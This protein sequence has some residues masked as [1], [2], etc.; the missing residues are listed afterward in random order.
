ML[1][2]IFCI[3]DLVGQPGRTFLANALPVL[4][5]SRNID[6]VVANAEN[7]A[8]GSGLTPQIFQK[9]LHYGVDVVTLGDHC[10]KR[11]EIIPIMASSDQLVRPAN[12]PPGAAGKP[13]TVVRKERGITIGVTVLLGRLYMK[14]MDCPYRTAD[15]MLVEIKKHTPIAIV[16]MHAE[17]TSEKIAMGW[18]LDGRA[19]IVFGTHTHVPTADARILP[20]GTAYITDLGMTGPYEGVLGRNREKVIRS[21]ISGMPNMYDIAEKDNRVAGVLVTVE[22]TTGRAVA[23]EQMIVDELQIEKMKEELKAR[24]VNPPDTMPPI[25]DD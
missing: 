7:A 14:P 13:Y 11:Y 25:N 8:G 19:S 15:Q 9:L 10:Y 21:M 6:V 22:T 23:I 20:N 4:I 18:Y 17:A 12:L 24:Q 2:N 5:K 1:I 3:G 16:E